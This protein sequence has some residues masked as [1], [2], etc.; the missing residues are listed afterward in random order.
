MWMSRMFGSLTHTQTMNDHQY[1]HISYFWY[2]LG[3]LYPWI[4]L[5][6]S[7]IWKQWKSSNLQIV[8]VPT[9]TP[10]QA[11]WT[12]TAKYANKFGDAKKTPAF[13]DMISE[14]Q[15]DTF[16][17][18][19]LLGEDEPND[20]HAY[21]F[22]WVATQPPASPCLSLL[23][24]FKCQRDFLVHSEWPCSNRVTKLT[25]IFI[26]SAQLNSEVRVRLRALPSGHEL[27]QGEHSGNMVLCN[28]I[29]GSQKK[30]NA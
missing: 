12:W 28:E 9:R 3:H 14:V 10:L 22:K 13:P 21:F 8:L 26:R 17:E 1:I 18:N 19:V 29:H 23:S 2:L 16:L 24:N 25:V 30:W 27:L 6:N 4:M 11:M 20:E 5:I 15:G 7:F